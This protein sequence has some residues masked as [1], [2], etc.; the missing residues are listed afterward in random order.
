MGQVCHTELY[1]IVL[2]IYHIYAYNLN[3]RY[4]ICIH[5]VNVFDHFVLMIHSYSSSVLN[6]RVHRDLW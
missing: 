2:I 3:I 5:Y 1:H 4:V 6:C